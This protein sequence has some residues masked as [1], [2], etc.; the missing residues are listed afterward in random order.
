MMFFFFGPFNCDTASP[1]P[2][3][4]RSAPTSASAAA[5]AASRAWGDVDARRREGAYPFTHLAHR[6]EEEIWIDPL[7]LPQDISRSVYTSV[8]APQRKGGRGDIEMMLPPNQQL[9]ARI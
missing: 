3:L 1:L 2:P 6:Q 4:S 5:A 7:K 9:L 8:S